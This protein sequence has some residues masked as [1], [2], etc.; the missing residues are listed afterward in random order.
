[1]FDISPLRLYGSSSI[2]VFI[3]AN[4]LLTFLP[5]DVPEKVEDVVRN[6][7]KTT[8]VRF[9]IAKSPLLGIFLVVNDNGVLLP[10]LTLEEEIKI[11]KA[12]GLNVEVLNTKYTAIS[13]LILASNRVALVSPLLEP[14]LRKKVGDVLGVE[15]VVDSIAN[16]PLVGAL[17]VVNSRGVLVAPEATDADLK[18]ISEYFK[19]RVD[20]GTINKGKSFLRGGI[21]V[22]DKGALVGD[23]TAGPELMRISQ[24]LG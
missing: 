5:N 1:M 3:A 13:N 18:K 10:S 15:V 17:A 24:V 21:V 2:G 19:T 4:N 14:Q 7:L 16:N 8:I 22:N 11:I 9:S 23:E 6:T 20:V 12:M